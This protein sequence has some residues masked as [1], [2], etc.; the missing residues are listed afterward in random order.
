MT[1][2]ALARAGARLRRVRGGAEDGFTLIYVLAVTTMVALLVGGTLV[3]TT[4]AIV[5]SVKAAY[6]QAADAAAQSGLQAFVAYVD[7]NCPA[8]T[9]SV[10]QCTLP[11]NYS[12]VVSI[13]IPNGS[14]N[15]TASYSWLAAKDPQSRYF[16]VK[17]V[18]AVKQ[19]GV[20]STKVWWATSAEARP[21]T[22]TTTGS[23]PVSKPSP[24]QRCSPA[25]RTAR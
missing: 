14:S 24:P 8:S 25:T 1:N 16:R 21:S 18:G 20:A 7:D 2:F 12:G 15:Y 19:G 9:T 10:A 4:G 13:P 22:P 17:A 23:S 11:T 3:V 5:P 6:S